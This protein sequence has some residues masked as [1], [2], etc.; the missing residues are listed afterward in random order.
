MPQRHSRETAAARCP[1]FPS[2]IAANNAVA[3]QLRTLKLIR[4]PK[5]KLLGWVRVTLRGLRMSLRFGTTQS[6]GRL[7]NLKTESN[8]AQSTI[9]RNALKTYIN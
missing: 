4:F 3:D 9:T 5:Q 1:R 7:K 2:S 8:F 6:L